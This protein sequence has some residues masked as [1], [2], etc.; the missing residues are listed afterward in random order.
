MSQFNEDVDLDEIFLPAGLRLCDGCGEARG[1][2]LVARTDGSLFPWRSACPC[3]G[4]TCRRCKVG[5]IRSPGVDYYDWR[6]GIW[7]HVPHFGGMLPCAACTSR[8]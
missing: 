6:D 1:V 2:A 4:I 5:M 3:E 8:E 7:S